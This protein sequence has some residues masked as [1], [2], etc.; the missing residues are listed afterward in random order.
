MERQRGSLEGVPECAESAA[1]VSLA[2]FPDPAASSSESVFGSV[3]GDGQGLGGIL[4]PVE[5]VLAVLAVFLENVPRAAEAKAPGC[6]ESAVASQS[7]AV[8]PLRPPAASSPT[9]STFDGVG[10]HPGDLSE[11]AES[12]SVGP[13]RAPLAGSQECSGSSEVAT[14]SFDHS[15][16]VSSFCRVR[17]RLGASP[18]PAGSESAV[19]PRRSL[20]RSSGRAELAGAWWPVRLHAPPS[21]LAQGRREPRSSS[22]RGHIHCTLCPSHYRPVSPAPHCLAATPVVATCRSRSTAPV[23]GLSQCRRP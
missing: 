3:P 16:T 20:S 18:G 11:P 6:S 1:V 12:E 5:S 10:P 21:S 2:E 15:S 23:Q 4:G 9:W 17:P 13:L 14:S 7:P 19:S 22:V 8:P